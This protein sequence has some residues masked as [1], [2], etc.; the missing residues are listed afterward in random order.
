MLILSPY[1]AAAASIAR[2][3]AAQQ[4]GIQLRTSAIVIAQ[5]WRDP[6]GRQAG[7]AQ[8]FRAVDIRPIDERMGREAGILIGHAKTS[9]PINATVV[10]TAWQGDRI[11]TS[12]PGDLKHL[13]AAARKRVAVIAC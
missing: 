2:L 1:P 5:V 4:H 12:D 8:L 7:L 6:K 3:R 11:L 9:D 10:L 13:A